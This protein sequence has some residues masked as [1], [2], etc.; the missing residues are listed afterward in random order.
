MSK[1]PLVIRIVHGRTAYDVLLLPLLPA[2]LPFQELH[3]NVL[4][5]I[6][7]QGMQTD[8]FAFF[9][10]ASIIVQLES[11]LNSL[12]SHTRKSIHYIFCVSHS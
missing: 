2:P 10:L 3:E 4:S 6:L 11:A 5:L 7:F 1:G 12:Y 9:L 8:S